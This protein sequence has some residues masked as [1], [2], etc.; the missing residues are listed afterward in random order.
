M[1]NMCVWGGILNRNVR[2]LESVY[3]SERNQTFF[4]VYDI[5]NLYTEFDV[6]RYT[7]TYPTHP[8]FQ[9][10]ILDAPSFQQGILDAPPISAGHIRY[11]PTSAEHIR[12][13]QHFNRAYSR[14]F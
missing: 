1:T 13:A 10:G 5:N 7:W 11:I 6:I 3:R 8:Q 14:L 2:K 12:H 4:F 9:Q